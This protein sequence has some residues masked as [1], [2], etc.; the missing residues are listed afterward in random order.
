M[1]GDRPGPA[2]AVAWLDQLVTELAGRGWPAWVDAPP[3]RLPRMRAANPAAAGLAEDIYAQPAADGTWRY[4]WPWA[5]PI[6][7]DPAGAAEVITRALWADPE[8]PR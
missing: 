8:P 4:W 6:A 7:A 2:D 5:E 1:P 3:G